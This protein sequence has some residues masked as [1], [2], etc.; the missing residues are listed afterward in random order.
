M[1]SFAQWTT[2]ATLV[3]TLCGCS[4]K[5]LEPLRALAPA[6][7]PSLRNGRSDAGGELD[8]SLHVAAPSPVR[9]G[10]LPV[11]ATVLQVSG[12]EV[13]LGSRHFSFGGP[14]AGSELTALLPQKVPVLLVPTS[15][16]YLAQAASLLRVLDDG[17]YSVFLRHPKGEVAYP[18]VLRDEKAFQAWLDE[19]KP[20]KVRVIQRSDGFELQT[21]VGK[22][23][24][25]DP[26][27]PT[28]P[29]RGGGPDLATLRKGLER[30]KHRFDSAPDLCFVP[31]FG[32]ELSKVAAAMSSDYGEGGEAIFGELCLVYPRG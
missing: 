29:I 22:L 4:D 31:S 28:V 2:T 19:P 20:G 9:G 8:D 27:G 3:C 18:L 23:P 24:G 5:N 10:K 1:A 12:D 13:T 30:L 26:N 7:L 21:N 32:T 11:G 16:V 14:D 17:G 25:A 6:P 15:E